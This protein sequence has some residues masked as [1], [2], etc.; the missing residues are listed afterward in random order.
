[1]GYPYLTG[2]ALCAA[3]VCFVLTPPAAR[4]GA[5][6]GAVDTP[7]DGRRMHTEP[8]PRSGG[9]AILTAFFLTWLIFGGFSW[10]RT[11]IAAGAAVL[12]T[13]GLADDRT[14]LPPAVKLI[15]QA[16]AVLP[17]ALTSPHPAATALWALTL[18]NAHNFI[19]GLDGLLGGVAAAE[20][21][22]LALMAMAADKPGAALTPLCLM[23]AALGFRAFNR[24]PAVLFMGDAGSTLIGYL[25]ACASTE[26]LG[27]TWHSA[28]IALATFA[29]PLLDLTAAVT[30]RLWLR[31]S[32]FTPDRRHIHHALVDRGL[33]H[34]R[35]SN[36]LTATAVG[37]GVVGVLLWGNPF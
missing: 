26:I 14:P 4:W 6:M 29:L 20:G 7:R 35:A 23:G 18:I 30:R 36:L 28:P 22:A 16:V 19:D 9:V 5:R 33:P 12:F 27:Y 21:G 32:P 31:Q 1:M 25:L 34:P 13:L 10:E 2:A 37:C 24:Y 11:A 3:L 15:G 17:P 8:V